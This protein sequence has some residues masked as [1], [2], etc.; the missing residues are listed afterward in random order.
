[1]FR[2]KKKLIINVNYDEAQEASAKYAEVSAR[3]GVIEAQMNERIN[4]IRDQFQEEVIQLAQ[5][6]ERQMEVLETFAKE[7]KG[8]WGKRKS[9][10]LLHS[11]IGFRTGTPKVTKDRKFSWDDVLDMVKEKFPSLVRVKC[12]L[13]KEAIIAMREEQ[14][15]QDLQKACFVD[16]IQDETFF[17]EAKLQTLLRVA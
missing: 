9:Y 13:D 14:Q 15:F 3:L 10:E 16:V 5:E 8:N 4:R 12:E 6:K 7:Q 17:V 1:M 11:V 2:E